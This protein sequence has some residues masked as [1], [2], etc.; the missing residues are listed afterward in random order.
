MIRTILLPLAQDLTSEPVLDAALSLA[1]RVNSHI[2]AMFILPDPDVA[3][4]YVPEM[5]FAA[6]ATRESIERETRQAVAGAKARFDNW[7]TRNHVPASAGVRLDGLLCDLVRAGRRNRNSYHALWPDQR[8]DRITALRLQ[9][10]SG[11]TLLR[12]GSLW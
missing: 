5:I 8:F 4:S 1:K 12:C 11:T 2:R 6:G 3:L 10:H 7:Q 9:C